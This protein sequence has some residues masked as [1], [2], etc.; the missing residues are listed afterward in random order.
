MPED[1]DQGPVVVGLG[2]AGDAGQDQD[3]GGLRGVVVVNPVKTNLQW[4]K[5]FGL[6]KYF[7]THLPS[8]REGKHL[9]R[10]VD[11]LQ[12]EVTDKSSHHGLDSALPAPKCRKVLL[13]D[14]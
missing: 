6:N 9:S 12:P 8:V 11:L 2:G 4:S 13:M 1:I 14:Q 5:Y 7:S 10:V 3:D